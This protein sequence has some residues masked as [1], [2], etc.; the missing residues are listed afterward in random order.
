MDGLKAMLQVFAVLF[1]LVF[2]GTW[3]S[4]IGT[5]EL[6]YMPRAVAG[7]WASS[8][9]DWI[10]KIHVKDRTVRLIAED[11]DAFHCVVDEIKTR[12][13]FFS[14]KTTTTVYCKRDAG[15]AV[16]FRA[17]CG[18]PITFWRIQFEQDASED[19]WV[20]IESTV[21]AYCGGDRWF[22]WQNAGGLFDRV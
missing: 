15:S 21:E 9:D 1:A 6:D 14:N 19:Y 11:G 20:G 3:V 8:H 18:R 4:N 13:A 7:H 5:R 12:N 10:R 2:I 16:A 17:A 22:P